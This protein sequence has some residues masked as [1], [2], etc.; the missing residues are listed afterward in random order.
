MQASTGGTASGIGLKQA[1][2][3]TLGYVCEEMGHFDEVVLDQEQVNNVLTA[4]VQGT[5][6]QEDS[7]VRLAAI[8]A[9]FNALEFAHTNF[10]NEGERNYLMQVICQGT[11]GDPVQIRERSF[12]C[13]VRIAA[14]HY[15]KLWPYMQEIFNLVQRAV[16]DNDEDVAKQAIEFWCTVCEEE[17]DVQ[18]VSPFHP[19]CHP[20]TACSI[21]NYLHEPLCK[22][23]HSQ[24]G[25]RLILVECW[26]CDLIARCHCLWYKLNSLHVRPTAP[27]LSQNESQL[28]LPFN[29]FI[30]SISSAP[31]I[32]EAL[33]LG[34]QV[35]PVSF[36]RN[37][38]QGLP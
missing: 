7:N 27:Y 11:M 8:T 5:A 15:D 24:I 25:A 1:T 30:H 31:M 36:Q 29:I 32:P 20:C 13:L 19:C 2:L 33:H 16:R 34:P 6:Q 22:Q 28:F 18:T 9:L 3:E 17:I 12:E 21:S 35:G 38:F 37:V 4:V 14:L 23:H 26:G 10:E